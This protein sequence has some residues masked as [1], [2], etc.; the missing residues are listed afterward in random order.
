MKKVTLL[1][2]LLA[3][4]CLFV[5]CVNSD[6][7]ESSR[8][9]VEITVQEPT[10]TPSTTP[11][12]ESSEHESVP[13]DI[14][15]NDNSHMPPATDDSSTDDSKTT[16]EPEITD[17]SNNTSDGPEDSPEDSTSNDASV[18]E[19][20]SEE[21]INSDTS[22]EESA[23]IPEDNP[24]DTNQEPP[25]KQ[26]EPN[27][28]PVVQHPVYLMKPI[29][30][31]D[32]WLTAPTYEIYG[33]FFDYAQEFYKSIIEGKDKE[34]EFIFKGDNKDN[35]AHQWISNIEQYMLHNRLPLQVD[36]LWSGE[37]KIVV[38]PRTIRAEL[39]ATNECINILHDIGIRD[40]VETKD[41]I[42][43]INDWM[44]QYL[45]YESTSRLSY[46]NAYLQ[47]KA[48]CEGYAR[49]FDRLCALTSISCFYDQGMVK[50][51]NTFVEHAWNYV[52]IGDTKYY[53][54]VCWNDSSRP[55]KYLLSTTLWDD[56]TT[57]LDMDIP[58]PSVP[59]NRITLP[60]KHHDWKE[61]VNP[62]LEEDFGE[63]YESAVLFYEALL[64][65]APT[66]RILLPGKYDEADAN[67]I[68]LLYEHMLPWSA[69]I[70]FSSLSYRPST[71]TVTAIYRVD[72]TTQALKDYILY[73]DEIDN[74][75]H[76]AGIKNGTTEAEALTRITQ[77]VV[78]NTTYKACFNKWQKILTTR[79]IGS[80]GYAQFLHILLEK[81][82]LSAKVSS[83]F[84]K[85]VKNDTRYAHS[86]IQVKLG[87]EW[88]YTDISYYYHKTYQN[89]SQYKY[90]LSQKLWESHFWE[91][92]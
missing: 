63:F 90:F 85:S 27:P 55:N 28:D 21:T 88:Y 69:P 75:L 57:H 19:D 31:V 8:E 2:F 67:F 6:D 89:Y 34:K 38:H 20:E 71:G 14:L 52:F 11:N 64:Q 36:W 26:P 7:T 51:S 35:N 37:L 59:S 32:T 29:T 41:A 1:T 39:Q 25:L 68:N 22:A 62:P 18:R 33:D 91:R 46:E 61:L 58:I 47:R 84:V 24:V 70:S 86:W 13:N 44:R 80:H 65:E 87:E 79:D 4:L 5:A 66:V 54:D 10:K 50:T 15:I 82:G 49:F 9:P 3:L 40:G 74:I 81:A 60:A 45:T 30:S 48:N 12:N 17:T 43:K 83:G 42:I 76:E 53:I 16:E 23:V 92:T 72:Y 78:D 56:H 77:W 73:D